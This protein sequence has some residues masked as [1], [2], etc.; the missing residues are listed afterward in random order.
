[1]A[2]GAILLFGTGKNR[3]SV[4]ENQN[5]KVM[6]TSP[7]KVCLIVFLLMYQPSYQHFNSYQQRRKKK[8]AKKKEEIAT[9][10]SSS[11]PCIEHTRGRG[12]LQLPQVYAVLRRMAI[13]TPCNFMTL[14]QLAEA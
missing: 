4:L 2:Q 8:V 14:M 9:A 11:S 12:L 5:P 3:F 1:L 10:T 6:N 13:L 7:P